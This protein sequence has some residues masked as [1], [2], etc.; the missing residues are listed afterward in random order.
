MAVIQR[1]HFYRTYKKYNKYKEQRQG[2]KEMMKWEEKITWK[3][4]SE[5]VEIN[6]EEEKLFF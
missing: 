5:I 1:Y 4:I 3:K 6:G 2:V